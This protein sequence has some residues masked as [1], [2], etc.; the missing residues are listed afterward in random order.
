[1]VPTFILEPFDGV[2][3]QL[4]PCSFATATPQ[5]SPWPLGWR[6][7]PASEFSRVAIISD[8]VRAA[9][10][11][12]SAKFE[13]V[14]LLRGVQS[15]VPCV[16][17]LP[18]LP[19]PSHVAILVRPV[20]VRAAVHLFSRTRDQAAPSFGRLAA[21]SRRRCPFITTRFKS[22]SWRSMSQLHNSFGRVASS[23]GAA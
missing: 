23:W 15:L 4:C 10:Q 13:L 7:K 20:V 9:A 12:T 21:T 17:L 5:T 8:G 11:P 2:G 18:R 22:A 14:D 19:G 1:M 16:R 6:H 3:A